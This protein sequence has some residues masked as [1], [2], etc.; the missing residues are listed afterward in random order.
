ME[1]YTWEVLPSELQTLDVVEQVAKEYQWTL[2]AL[3]KR[4]LAKQN[5]A[6]L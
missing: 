4:G 2:N 1:T 3:Q 6:I 5:E